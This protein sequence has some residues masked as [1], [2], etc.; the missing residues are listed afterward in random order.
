MDKASVTVALAFFVAI[1]LF[2]LLTLFLVY[3]QH[4]HPARIPSDTTSGD[5]GPVPAYT[6]GRLR[7]LVV[8]VTFLIWS[9]LISEHLRPRR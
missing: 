9:L 3:D 8:V 2:G 1:G 4:P 5:P 7:L 6:V